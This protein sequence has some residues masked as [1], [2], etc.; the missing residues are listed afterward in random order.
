MGLL[1]PLF[2]EFVIFKEFKDFSHFKHIEVNQHSGDLGN[3]LF[4]VRESLNCREQQ[5]SQ[6]RSLFFLVLLKELVEVLLE[7]RR[8]QFGRSDLRRD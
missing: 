2:E 6:N 8:S 1:D 3:S 4:T 7:G 5:F